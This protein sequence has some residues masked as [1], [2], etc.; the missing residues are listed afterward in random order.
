MGF[1]RFTK[2]EGHDVLSP[3]QHSE[4]ETELRKTGKK[5]VAELDEQELKNLDE[6][7]DKTD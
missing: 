3:D 4:V 7:L 5:S 1:Q 6:A 2:A